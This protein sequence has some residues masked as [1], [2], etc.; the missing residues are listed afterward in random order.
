MQSRVACALAFL[1]ALLAGG[2]DQ[3]K[4]VE[5]SRVASCGGRR[6]GGKPRSQSHPQAR[7][8]LAGDM[9]AKAVAKAK[10]AAPTPDRGPKT[11][12]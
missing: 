3:S 5:R 12:G 6:E 4:A 9:E 2:Y 8:S 10:A 11:L 7:A 1:A